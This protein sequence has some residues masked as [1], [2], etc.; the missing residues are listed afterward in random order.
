M[1]NGY[2][3]NLLVSSENVFPRIFLDGSFT[4]TFILYIITFPR[5]FQLQNFLSLF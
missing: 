2:F 1:W 5:L 4:F 3:M